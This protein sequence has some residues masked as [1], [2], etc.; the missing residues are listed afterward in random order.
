M[1]DD[2]D[3]TVRDL[4][5]T[6]HTG[7]PPGKP[8]LPYIARYM[9]GVVTEVGATTCTVRDATD[10]AQTPVPIANIPFL[11]RPSVGNVVQMIQLPHQRLVLGV[12][13]GFDYRKV[14]SF[15]DIM[16]SGTS[17]GWA[18]FATHLNIA[19]PA[20]A[21]TMTITVLGRFGFSGGTNVVQFRIL[22]EDGITNITYP[23][24]VYSVSALAAKWAPLSLGAKKNYAAG[25]SAGF[26]LQYMVDTSNVYVESFCIVTLSPQ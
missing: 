2:L 3:G 24:G 17:T 11:V 23:N 9:T 4:S 7:T 10:P 21:Y 18:T 16:N 15:Q 6:L 26:Y 14:Y 8:P 20:E 19:T 12:L 25:A 13:G 22:A 1:G 5:A